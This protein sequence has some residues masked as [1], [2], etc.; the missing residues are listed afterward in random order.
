MTTAYRDRILCHRRCT[1]GEVRPH[2][3]NWRTHPDGQRAAVTALVEEVGISRSVLGFLPDADKPSSWSEWT[4][5]A[6]RDYAITCLPA[7]L[8]LIDGHGRRDWFADTVLTV[9][10][11][12]VTDDEARKLLLSMD[13]TAGLA[14]TDEEALRQLRKVT[15]ADAEVLNQMWKELDRSDEPL[16]RETEASPVTEDTA[17]TFLIVVTCR[18]EKHQGELLAKF[19]KQG[20]KCKPVLG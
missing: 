13:P 14:G 3:L 11:L 19:Q 9:E 10:V 17:E 18:S 15:E 5:E 6:R 16:T 8:M 7:K 12:D 2:P 20:L 4:H 1:L